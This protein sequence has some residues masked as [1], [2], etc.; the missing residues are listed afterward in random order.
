MDDRREFLVGA[1]ACVVGSLATASLARADAFADG[2]AAYD[3][4]DY[5]ET[6]RIWTGLARRSDP[7]A[8]VGLAGLY[9]SGQGVQRDLGMAADLY[10]RA[11]EQGSDDGQLN[12][13]RMYAEGVG[14]PRD[15]VQAY[16]WLSLAA[17]RGRTWAERRRTTLRAEMSAAQLSAAEQQ[18]DVISSRTR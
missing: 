11:A 13:G 14:V 4:G 12:L 1:V 5:P 3:A 17:A 16:V 8:Q 2:L 15:L 18:I 6:V 9:R 7:R 10:R